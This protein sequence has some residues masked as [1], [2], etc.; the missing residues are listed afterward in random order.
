MLQYFPEI[1]VALARRGLLSLQ[2]GIRTLIN[3][4]HSPE[5]DTGSPGITPRS[6]APPRGEEKESFPLAAGEFWNRHFWTAFALLV[7]ALA[8]VIYWPVRHFEFLNFD[9]NSYVCD[10]PYIAKGLTWETV[11]WAFEANLAYFSKSAE[12]W[13][14]LTLLSR[15]LDSQLFGVN[16]GAFHLSSAL[17]HC[18]NT[19]LLAVALTKLTGN[20]SRSGLVALIFLVHPLSLEPVCWLSARKDLVSACFFFVTLIAYAGYAKKPCGRT[21]AGL[22]FCYVLAVMAKPMTVSTPFLLLALD[23]WPLKRWDAARDSQA[24]LR[25]LLEKIPLLALA[26][27][28]GFLAFVSQKNWGA[29]EP[30]HSYALDQ[31]IENAFLSYATYLRRIA[32]PTD[33]AIYYSYPSSL[34][35][36]GIA[37]MTL[38]TALTYVVVRSAKRLPCLTVGWLWFG[39]VLGPVIG[40]LQYGAQAMA[41]RYAYPSMIGIL[42]AV[43]W[44]AGDSLKRR[45]EIS[46]AI[47]AAL[48]VYFTILSAHHVDSFRNSESAFYNAAQNSANNDLCWFNL[49]DCYMKRQQFLKARE[50]LIHAAEIDPENLRTWANLG[51]VDALIGNDVEAFDAYAKSVELSEYDPGQ[52]S[53][54]AGLSDPHR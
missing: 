21:Y 27:G 32:F 25:L 7:F 24:R 17:W 26:S 42:V 54:L 34:L 48:L 51:S 41:D 13:S 11:R 6:P 36:P 8:S 28:A 10:N 46:A 3:Q 33:L 9:D 29:L 23:F 22:L 39:L 45:R 20:R 18:I 14:P 53:Y 35:V 38:I 31:R 19:V 37:C 52:V 43:V 50:A 44:W 16:A 49:A 4:I 1:H 40:L 15:L 5:H 47:A 30:L 12:Y 2:T